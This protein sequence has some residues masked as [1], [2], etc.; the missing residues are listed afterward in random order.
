MTATHNPMKTILVSIIFV[1]SVYYVNAQITDLARVEYT[2]FPQKQSDNSFK[3][4]RVFAN[5]PIKIGNKGAYL[6]PGLEYRNVNFD[7]EDATNFNAE[8]LDVFH[9]F[10]ASLGYTWKISEEWRLAFRA[11]SIVASNFEADGLS[12]DDFLVTGSA[13]AIKDRTGEGEA[14]KPWRLIIGL[15]YSTVA[16]RPFPLPFVNYYKKFHSQWSYGLGIP[17][18]NLR[19]FA[20]DRSTFQAFATLDGFFANIQ[21]NR[22]IPNLET[23][24]Q[25]GGE[26]GNISMTIVLAGLGYEYKIMSHLFF[27]VYGGHTV[28][29]DI[30]LRDDDGDDV[31]TIN[32]T[33][34]WYARGGIKVK[35]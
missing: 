12:K 15:N 26:A 25:P 32:D 17:K 13:Y 20:T 19:Y 9:S 22:S 18:T 35:I 34:S 5:L 30:R 11:G 29:N 33:N 14:N 7:Y 2:Y 4:F 6:V 8:S 28:L 27:Y 21:S 10:Q 3:R 16:G 31:L 24:K 23:E 1:F